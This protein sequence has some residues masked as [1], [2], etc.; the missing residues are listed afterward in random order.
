MVYAVRSD[1]T[2]DSADSVQEEVQF[3]RLA[4]IGGTLLMMMMLNTARVIVPCLGYTT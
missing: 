2:D 1:Q 3:C 4:K